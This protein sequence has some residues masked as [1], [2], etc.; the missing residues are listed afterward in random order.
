MII[1]PRHGRLGTNIGKAQKR[2]PLS[3]SLGNIGLVNGTVHGLNFVLL[4]IDLFLN[5][6][7]V[8]TLVY[9]T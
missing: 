1:L 7:Q 4:L 8:R 2:V 3:R 5:Q 6:L 9:V